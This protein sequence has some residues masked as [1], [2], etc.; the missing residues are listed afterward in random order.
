MMRT[1]TSDQYLNNKPFFK[2]FNRGK[3]IT[4]K[5]KGIIV[6]IV[7]EA[8]NRSRK[9]IQD[10]RQALELAENPEEPRRYLLHDLYD[11]LMIDGHLKSIIQTR[12]LATLSTRFMIVDKKSGNEVPEKTELLWTSWFI[13]LI[14]NC[15]DAE[16]TGYRLIELKNPEK[17]TF[18]VVPP[19]NVVPQKSLVLFEVAGDEGLYYDTP[20][21]DNYLIQV[22]EEEDLGI[23]NDIIPQL[24]WKR[25]AQQAW[26]EFGEKFGIPML[27]ATTNKSN[28]KDI[29][30]I[31][32]MLTQLGEAAQAV[33]PEGTTI[34][35]KDG[36]NAGNI[37]VFDKQIERTNGEMSKRVLGGT[38]VSDNGS[39]RSQ[40]EVHERTLDDKIGA[41]DRT[42]IE[43]LVNDQVL[44]I[45]RAHGMP[46]SEN[47]RFAFDAKKKTDLNKL[48]QIVKEVLE[49]YEVPEEWISKTFN[50]PIEGKKK[51]TKGTKEG[52]TAN[53]NTPLPV[54]WAGASE[55]VNFPAYQGYCDHTIEASKNKTFEELEK[56]SEAILKELWKKGKTDKYTL[57]KSLIAGTWLQEGL[58]SGWGK[59]R[60]QVEYN[61]T[62]HVALAFMEYNLFHFSHARELAGLQELNQLLF[63]KEK[64]EIRSFADF[65]RQAEPLLKQLNKNW[66]R[67]ERNFA[68][69]TA[70]NASAFQLHWNERNSVTKYIQYQTVG[71]SNVRSEHRLL[72]GLIFDI[73]DPDARRLYAPN[74]HGCRC[75]FIQYMG[76]PKKVTKGIEAIEALALDKDTAQ[77]MLQNRGDIK[78]V[79]TA[80]QFYI[81]SKERE[82]ATSI[83]KLDYARYGL[84]KYAD[85]KGLKTLTL[86]NSINGDNVNELF[87]PEK[88]TTYMGFE[89]Y[90]KRK[91]LLE[92]TDFKKN[93]SGGKI[94]PGENRHRLFP[95]VKDVL[96]NPD[97]V[98]M[99]SQKSGQIEYRYIKF[100]DEKY[101]V[102]DVVVKDSA[103]IKEWFYTSDESYRKGLL[104]NKY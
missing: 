74:G 68:V 21:W 25:N 60:M 90:T 13:R 69:A 53:F 67:T 37:Q 84:K 19:R 35:I 66:L 102:V 83:S 47:E 43:F 10:W 82:F 77:K 93:T 22:G 39:S 30:H 49:D 98:Y 26:A 89:D 3:K 64:L 78:Q 86:D 71:D 79:F 46:F 11:E 36:A 57:S 17:K 50:I 103:E 99:A 52:A 18:K 51:K 104:I 28:E 6:K 75:E 95:H 88:N 48:W 54:G 7:Q 1:L 24:I 80:N 38:M 23:I 34:D 42:S 40:S 29:D 94:K 8:K 63:D 4:P 32:E 81:E 72:H 101:L 41:S 9:E 27:T 65:K 100:Y 92:K 61:A 45:L 15:L 70:Q 59:R 2:F 5:D 85:M 91:M 16:Y 56:Q 73:N 20:E 14:K 33:L 87:K 58:F 76:N 55:G 12:K 62:D 44:P 31:E 96:K 97:E